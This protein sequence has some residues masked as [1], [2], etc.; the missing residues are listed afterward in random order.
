MA[1]A[2]VL[3]LAP[4]ARADIADPHAFDL[5]AGRPCSTPDVVGVIDGE[6]NCSARWDG[7]VEPRDAGD[8]IRVTH[9]PVQHSLPAPPERHVVLPTVL[10]VSL[11]G[12]FALGVGLIMRAIRK[13][14]AR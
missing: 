6:G 14:S 10:Y 11:A 2:V 7:I 3:Q 4:L 13:R 8:L 5:P 9:P 12:A 1:L